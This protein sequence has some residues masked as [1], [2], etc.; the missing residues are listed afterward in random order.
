MLLLSGCGI[1]AVFCLDAGLPALREAEALQIVPEGGAALS[2]GEAPS[3]PAPAPSAARLR[4]TSSGG[5]VTRSGT[6]GAVAD[7]AL[8]DT[9]ATPQS[10]RVTRRS[11][12]LGSAGV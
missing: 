7:G 4:A 2:D 6:R 12:R 10:K 3:Q 5:R 11:T 8:D 1:S 9:A